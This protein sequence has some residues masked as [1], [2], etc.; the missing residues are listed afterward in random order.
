MNNCKKAGRC[1]VA[2]L[3]CL[4]LFC[5]DAPFGEQPGGTASG[6]EPAGFAGGDGTEEDPYLVETAEQLDNVRNHLDAHFRQVADI[7]LDAFSE[8][9]GWEPIGSWTEHDARFSGTFDGGDYDIVNVRIDRSYGYFIGL[10]AGFDDGARVENMALK[11]VS[12]A[13]KEG[14]GALAGVNRGQIRSCYVE[15]DVSGDMV[16]GGLAGRNDGVIRNSCFR[17]AV[18]GGMAAGGIA[19]TSGGDIINTRVVAQVKV[20][21]SDGGG[22]AGVNSAAGTIS[23]TYAEGVVA[24][25]AN[26]GGLAGNNTGS[27]NNSYALANVSGE[28]NIG[29]LAGRNLKDIVNSY[30]AGEVTGVQRVGGLVG[31][32]MITLQGFSVEGTVTS[33]FYDQTVTGTES[34]GR[35]FSRTTQQMMREET[36]AD[37]DFDATWAIDE[38]EGYPYLQWQEEERDG[39]GEEKL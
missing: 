11:N 15:G 18:N 13:G 33:S 10:F 14:V 17:G 2:A 3:A 6:Q 20:K 39:R 9:E 32:D 38:G 1:V 8:N 29:G 23:G 34:T 30:A 7:D 16:V 31:K 28:E 19:G 24:G 21:E 22:I 12:V 25:K 4:V 5:A 35:G 26:A 36:F 27:I 37:W